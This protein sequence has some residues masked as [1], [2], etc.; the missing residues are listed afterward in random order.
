MDSGTLDDDDKFVAPP[1]WTIVR[2]TIV[3]LAVIFGIVFLL[4]A[5]V[6]EPIE[7]YSKVSIGE[8]GLAGVFAGVVVVDSTP[9]LTHD[10]ILFTAFFAGYPPIALAA[11]MAV[12]S[13]IAACVNWVG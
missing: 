4:G 2:H 12:A 9:F 13:L 10:P 7:H 3:G 8:F 5:L 11:V 6:R 1:P